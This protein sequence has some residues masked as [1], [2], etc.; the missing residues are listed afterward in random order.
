[1]HCAEYK[2]AQ[3]Q[4][5]QKQRKRSAGFF[6][7]GRA[8]KPFAFSFFPGAAC[9]QFIKEGGRIC[10]RARGGKRGGNDFAARGKKGGNKRK[11]GTFSFQF[12]DRGL[13]TG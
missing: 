8:G 3:T 10:N 6:Y 13:I 9:Q 11:M 7:V 4:A 12:P 5:E 1:M 2:S